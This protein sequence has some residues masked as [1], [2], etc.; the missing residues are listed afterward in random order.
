MNDE[1]KSDP[2]NAEDKP[3]VPAEGAPTGDSPPFGAPEK[4]KQKPSGKLPPFLG[5]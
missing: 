2:R 1:K 3:K 5:G 4:A